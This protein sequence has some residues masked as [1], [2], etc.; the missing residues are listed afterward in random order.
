[1]ARKEKRYHY[2][3]KTVCTITNKFYVG[4][5][6]TDNL[7]DGYK[8]SGKRL[9]YSIKKYGSKNHI[10]EILEFLPNRSSLKAREAEIINEKFL[11]DEM[12]MNIALGGEGNGGGFF[13]E[14]HM[15]KC[16][17]AGIIAFRK[18]LESDLDMLEK[19]RLLA[20]YARSKNNS[21]PPLFTGKFHSEETK[22][23]MSK[24]ASER[25]GDKNS[26]Y[27]TF[28]ITNGSENKKVRNLEDIP[29]GWYRGRSY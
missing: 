14:E 18:K 10:V 22:Q 27:G 13:S 6:S 29:D 21:K 17:S 4:M 25:T 12:C 8:G 2:I 11:Q 7:E 3:Y 24:I 26:Q 9:R 1:M 5:H 23:K 28:W 15:S 19:F 20:E 16:S